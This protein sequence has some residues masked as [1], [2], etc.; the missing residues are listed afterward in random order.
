MKARMLTINAA[1]LLGT[2]LAF[3]FVRTNLPLWVIGLI[4]LLA[5]AAINLA[6]YHGTKVDTTTAANMRR[7]KAGLVVMW[8][9]IL[10]GLL[11]TWLSHSHA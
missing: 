8:I 3:F 5:F 9:L 6:A 4:V 2:C 10:M 7:S 1:A 11:L